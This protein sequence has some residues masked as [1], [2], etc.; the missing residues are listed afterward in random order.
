MHICIMIYLIYIKFMY[1]TMPSHKLNSGSNDF[2]SES[3]QTIK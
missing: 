3:Y 1:L 2:S